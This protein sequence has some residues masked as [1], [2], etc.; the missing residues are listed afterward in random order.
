MPVHKPRHFLTEHVIQSVIFILHLAFIDLTIKSACPDARTVALA[1]GRPRGP[2]MGPPCPWRACGAGKCWR[3]SM[4]ARTWSPGTPT[5][6][7]RNGNYEIVGVCAGPQAGEWCVTEC[8]W[9]VSRGRASPASPPA[10]GSGTH[11]PHVGR[12]PSVRSVS[13]AFRARFGPLHRR[14]SDVA[15]ATRVTAF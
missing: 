6:A 1:V 8:R 14:M 2:P 3:G 7:C 12:A 13:G 15:P 9:F 10:P 4:R 5:C 11:R